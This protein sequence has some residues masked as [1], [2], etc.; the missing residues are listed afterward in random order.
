M[1][2]YRKIEALVVLLA[3]SMI[4]RQGMFFNYEKRR[5]A[6]KCVIWPILGTNFSTNRHIDQDCSFTFACPAL[7]VLGGQSVFFS[8]GFVKGS[9]WIVNLPKTWNSIFRSL[10]SQ[11]ISV[12]LRS[13]GAGDFMLDSCFGSM[14]RSIRHV[15][16]PETICHCFCGT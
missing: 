1:H 16:F 8:M 15:F 5:H 6:R 7:I 4:V 2:C 10:N 12:N 9:G 11:R 13:F 3:N 14:N